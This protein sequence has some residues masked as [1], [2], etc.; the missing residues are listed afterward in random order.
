MLRFPPDTC[1]AVEQGIAIVE[2]VNY[3]RCT[4]DRGSIAERMLDAKYDGRLTAQYTTCR[5]FSRQ[6]SP[7]ACEAPIP[8]SLLSIV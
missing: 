4:P 3:T 8:A 2:G 7:A 1:Y 6:N 5:K